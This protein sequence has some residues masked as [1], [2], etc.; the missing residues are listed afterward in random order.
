MLGDPEQTL[1][2]TL[3]INSVNDLKLGCFS[4][5]KGWDKKK[6][7]TS[8]QRQTRESVYLILNSRWKNMS[9]EKFITTGLPLGK[10]GIQHLHYQHISGNPKTRNQ[11]GLDLVVFYRA[12]HKPTH[13]SL[14]RWNVSTRMGYS[15]KSGPTKYTQINSR[16]HKLT[17]QNCKVNKETGVHEQS[18]AETTGGKKPLDIGIMRFKL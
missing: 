15:F 11:S 2:L 18:S 16:E 6:K 13:I 9:S 3:L 17:L 4:S 10:F 14:Q 8:Q 12:W 1:I 7:F 5:K